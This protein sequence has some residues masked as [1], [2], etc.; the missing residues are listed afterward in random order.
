MNQ[1]DQKMNK[2]NH[3]NGRENKVKKLYCTPRLQLLESVVKMTAGS[4]NSDQFDVFYPQ[5]P[6][7]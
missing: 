5:D 3:S 2:S 6:M 7:S 1:N 4:G